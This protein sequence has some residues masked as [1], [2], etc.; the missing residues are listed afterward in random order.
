MV[1]SLTHQHSRVYTK[2]LLRTSKLSSGLPDRCPCSCPHSG[3]GARKGPCLIRCWMCTFEIT[4][5]FLS[6]AL[7]QFQGQCM[8]LTLSINQISQESSTSHSRRAY[9]GISSCMPPSTSL[10]PGHSPK[11]QLIPGTRVILRMVSLTY[12]LEPF[13]TPRLFALRYECGDPSQQVQ[14][15]SQQFHETFS[16]LAKTLIFKGH[17]LPP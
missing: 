9:N 16:N 10:F 2:D 6:T 1:Q 17:H 8:V 14:L 3:H 7:F 13:S 12:L 11:D 15:P 5:H 4:G